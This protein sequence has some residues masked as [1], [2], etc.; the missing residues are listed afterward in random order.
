MTTGRINQVAV[1]TGR[2]LALSSGPTGPH[3]GLGRPDWIGFVCVAPRSALTDRSFPRCPTEPSS[4]AGPQRSAG[5]VESSQIQPAQPL[6]PASSPA[7]TEECAVCSRQ[8]ALLS[9]GLAVVLTL[10]LPIRYSYKP[11]INGCTFSRRAASQPVKVTDNTSIQAS[12]A[13]PI[14]APAAIGCNRP[15]PGVAHPVRLDCCRACT[16]FALQECFRGRLSTDSV[17][18]TDCLLSRHSAANFNSPLLFTSGEAGPPA[19][20]AQD[21]SRWQ[22]RAT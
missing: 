5:A 17:E 10:S 3:P 11:L 16:G 18:P 7:C 6:S 9:V 8:K 19:T 20:P 12:A 21:A 2:G 15:S 22:K 13:A 4:Q 1:F 14:A